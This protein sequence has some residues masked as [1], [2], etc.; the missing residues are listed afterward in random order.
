MRQI[1]LVPDLSSCIETVARREH[2]RVAQ[3]LLSTE[4][5]SE[6]LMDKAETLRL[7]LETADLRKLRSESEKHL[8]EGRK[9][10]FV[11]SL[12]DGIVQYDMQVF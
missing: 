10:T 11:V 9:V 4:A 6:E 1:E 3:E 5:P 12:R 8:L 2:E 7:F